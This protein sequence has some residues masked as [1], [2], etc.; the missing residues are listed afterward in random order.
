M[1]VKAVPTVLLGE[2]TLSP[3]RPSILRDVDT[4]HYV[5]WPVAGKPAEVHLITRLNWPTDS[6]NTLVWRRKQMKLRK[7]HVQPV[8]NLRHHL[9]YIGSNQSV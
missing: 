8:E 5:F 7:T 6:A 3:N 4:E 9:Q 1:G 2:H